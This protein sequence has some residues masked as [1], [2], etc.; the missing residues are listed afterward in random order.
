MAAHFPDGA[1]QPHEILAA[2]D[3]HLN[4]GVGWKSAEKGIYPAWL[5]GEYAMTDSKVSALASISKLDGTEKIPGVS[6]GATKSLTPSEIREYMGVPWRG[7]TPESGI[8]SPVCGNIQG[9]AMDIRGDANGHHFIPFVLTAEQA[10]AGLSTITLKFLGNSGSTVDALYISVYDALSDTLLG[11]V[12]RVTNPNGNG[13]VAFN[14]PTVATWPRQA[15]IGISC[16]VSGGAGAICSVDT[17]AILSMPGY[18]AIASVASSKG[19]S[20]APGIIIGSAWDSAPSDL[21]G[22]TSDVANIDTFPFMVVE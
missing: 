8:I 4:S 15:Y 21:S 20:A 9:S 22:L 14:L 19:L 7:R 2:M 5:E 12:E 18:S 1:P 16:G 10:S 6:G 13:W 11:E 17:S 3:Y